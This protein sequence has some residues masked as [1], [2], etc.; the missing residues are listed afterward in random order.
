MLM[1][2]WIGSVHSDNAGAQSADGGVASVVYDRCGIANTTFLN[3]EEV[4]YKVFYQWNFIW[5][6]AGEVVFRVLET[7]THYKIT[8]D[9]YT[10]GAYDKIYP[11]DDHYETHL[12]KK[13]LLPDY[14]MQELHE[15]KYNRYEK[16]HFDQDNRK[17]TAW[18]GKF[19][20]AELRKKEVAV[21]ACMHDLL[22]ILYY[23]RNLDFNTF[24][25]GQTMPVE[26]FMGKEYPLTVRVIDKNIEQRVHGKGKYLTHLFS[27]EV[28]V[29]ELFKESDQMK[30]WV[31]ADSN[32]I[33][34]LIESPLSVGKIKAVIK[35]YKGLR[36]D[37]EAD[38]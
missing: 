30:I 20:D 2:L 3:G 11:V 14:Y 31:S 25:P 1:I 32:K 37:L 10:R 8:A 18:K 23:V 36:F 26:I 16:Y 33:P 21:N 6:N 17:V 22:S 19:K 28:I 24:E 5:I 34:V 4:I 7:P 27:P 9:G 12:N 15:G 29:G 35:E 38:L 13:T